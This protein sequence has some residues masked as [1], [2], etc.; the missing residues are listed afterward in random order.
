MVIGSLRILVE[1]PGNNNLKGKRRVIKS[2]IER[3]RNKYNVSVSEIDNLD[4]HQLA[5]LGIA[6]VSNSA[7]MAD[8]VLNQIVDFVEAYGEVSLLDYMIEIF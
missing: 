2:L 6:F 7:K 4:K 8:K 3:I 1:I 5:T